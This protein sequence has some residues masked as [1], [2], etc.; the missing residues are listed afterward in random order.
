MF[1]SWG[2]SLRTSALIEGLDYEKLAASIVRFV[3]APLGH[4][5][6]LRVSTRREGR[7]D[8]RRVTL[9]AAIWVDIGRLWHFN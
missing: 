7:V 4:Y 2:C 5:A 8:E 6:L 3:V 9:K 1:G